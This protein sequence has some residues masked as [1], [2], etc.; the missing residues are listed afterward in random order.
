MSGKLITEQ[1]IRIYM[2]T[3]NTGH[4]Q[5]TAAAKA[6]ISERSG[7]RIENG[8]H[9]MPKA[10]DWKTRKDPFEEVWSSE[11]EP[12]LEQEPALTGITL[13]DYLITRVIISR[14]IITSNNY[15][16]IQIKFYAG[17]AAPFSP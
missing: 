3:K 12:L 9:S 2:S 16:Q 4:I 6:G 10:R 1:Q 11:L 13:W 15:G 17:P 14:V 8:E 5:Q 7:R